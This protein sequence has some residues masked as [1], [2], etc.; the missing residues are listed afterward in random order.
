MDRRSQ[1]ELL[2]QVSHELRTPINGVLGMTELLFDTPLNDEQREYLEALQNSAE[3]LLYLLNDI[4][5]LAKVESGRLE[6]D[7]IDFGLRHT[8]DEAMRAFALRAA[9]K[10][11]ELAVDVAA[12]TPDALVGDPTRLR[13]VLVSVSAVESDLYQQ[14]KLRANVSM[15]DVS[16]A[17]YWR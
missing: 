5:D 12:D 13:Q 14:E 9:Q 4:L 3:S 7:P 6:L 2:A 15:S 1:T 10:D 11:V 17:S 16:G 8:I